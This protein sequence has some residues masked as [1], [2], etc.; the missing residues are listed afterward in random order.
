MEKYPSKLN[1]YNN[2]ELDISIISVDFEQ[3]Y[4]MQ[5]TLSNSQKYG[6]DIKQEVQLI[7]AYECLLDINFLQMVQIDGDRLY[8]GDKYGMIDMHVDQI[9]SRGNLIIWFLI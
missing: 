8:W 7:P 4:L 2:S 9:I 6:I 5:V 1:R 3:D